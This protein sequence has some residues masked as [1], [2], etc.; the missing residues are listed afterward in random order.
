MTTVPY[1]SRA[2]RAALTN[3]DV[4]AWLSFRGANSGPVPGRWRNVTRAV[5]RAKDQL[6]RAIATQRR[7]GNYRW[8]GVG[9]EGVRCGWG[10]GPLA[11]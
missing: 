6:E 5:Q 2:G 1:T 11:L 4:G 8:V 9:L 10:N 3:R 7:L